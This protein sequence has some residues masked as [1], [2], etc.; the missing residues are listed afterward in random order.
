LLSA[1]LV[2]SE[3]APA[4]PRVLLREPLAYRLV[5]LRY[6]SHHM[7]FNEEHKLLYC[8]VP[9]VACTEFMRLFFRLQGRNQDTDWKENPHFKTVKPLFSLLSN[10]PAQ[11]TNRETNSGEENATAIINDPEWTKMVFFRDPA[12]RLLSAWLDKFSPK[13][14]YES[15]YGMHVFKK[16]RVSF[17]E[18]VDLV[19]AKNTRTNRP[20]GLH[21]NTN[22]HW[23]LQ[24]YMCNLEKFLPAYNFVGSF[25]SLYSH[26]RRLLEAKGLWEDYGAT[27]WTSTQ[28]TPEEKNGALF[29][30]NLA[31]HQ[32]PSKNLTAYYTPELL[33]RVHRAYA[34]DYEMLHAIG[35]NHDRP[36]TGAAW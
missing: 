1:A 33:A 31:E 19:T 16:Q 5:E 7:Y 22:P 15:V 2:C 34:P 18:F 29:E 17:P 24:R 36:T 25:D 32:T 35:F 6:A 14:P 20:E 12:E 11:R 10:R 8:S 28:A 23:R 21:A 27:G 13:S 3:E 9:K 26:T 30:K 4:L